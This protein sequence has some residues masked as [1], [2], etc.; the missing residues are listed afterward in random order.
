MEIEDWASFSE[1]FSDS[2]VYLQDNND[3]ECLW[4]SGSM[5]KLQFRKDISKLPHR[6]ST[7][8]PLDLYES[9]KPLCRCFLR[10]S[11]KFSSYHTG[12]ELYGHLFGSS[13]TYFARNKEKEGE[14]GFLV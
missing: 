1:G 6:L 10:F 3:E 4:D 7:A 13:P 9:H 5:P 2:E 8:R 12:F 11:G 14:C